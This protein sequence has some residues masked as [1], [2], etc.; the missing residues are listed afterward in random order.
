ML[1]ANLYVPG[2]ISMFKINIKAP[3]KHD[4]PIYPLHRL[5]SWVIFQACVVEFHVCCT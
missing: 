5:L 3:T 2:E 4:S 1:V